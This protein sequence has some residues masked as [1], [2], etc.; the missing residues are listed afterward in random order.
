MEDCQCEHDQNVLPDALTSCCLAHRV[1]VNALGSRKANRRGIESNDGINRKHGEGISLAG[2][3]WSNLG[4][5]G[6]CC[7]PVVELEE[8]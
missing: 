5:G 2:M 1:W 7:R 3:S 4:K 8:C 6:T